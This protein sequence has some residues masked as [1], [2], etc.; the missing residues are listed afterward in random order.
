MALYP[1]LCVAGAD[2]ELALAAS[3]D[4][5][6]IA[7]E[8]TADGV[9]IFF[10]T[11]ALRDRAAESL[12]RALPNA[13]VTP[14][15]VDDEDW[16]R[17]SQESLGPITVDRITVRPGAKGCAATATGSE[18]EIVILPSMGFGTGHHATTRLC[19]QALQRLDVR[20]R[21]VLDVG[22]GSGILALAARALGAS[23]S[24]GIDA[25]P[26]AIE[27]ARA[28]LP[29]NPELDQVTFTV[30][31]LGAGP[32][33]S[34]DIV[35]ANLTGA[36]LCRSAT[37]LVESLRAGGHLTISGVLGEERDAVRAAFRRLPVAWE[38]REDEWV[39]MT[40][41]QAAQNTV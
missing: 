14:R 19:L 40:F 22:T 3:D 21:S 37:R 7:A 24:L 16:A 6:P 23:R 13:V 20:G 18:V 30:R 32:L 9:T 17:R 38:A 26:D 8:P 12:V 25:D 36:L 5:T 39:A 28:N 11:A 10:P 41:S 4:Y 29:L 35:T 27:S 1:A 2:E 33:P 15:D 31:D 34:A